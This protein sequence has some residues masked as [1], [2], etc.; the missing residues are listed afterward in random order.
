MRITEAV[1][2]PL[3]LVL[4]VAVTQSPTARFAAV[5]VRVVL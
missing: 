5:A 2:E 3:E 4:P 1:T